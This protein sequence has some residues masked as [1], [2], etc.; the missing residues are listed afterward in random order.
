MSRKV[1]A[2][3]A[4]DRSEYRRKVREIRRRSSEDDVGPACVFIRSKETLDKID[5]DEVIT[6]ERFWSRDDAVEIAQA[7]NNGLN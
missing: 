6:C 4:V 2:I 3:L 1:C 5:E 7:A